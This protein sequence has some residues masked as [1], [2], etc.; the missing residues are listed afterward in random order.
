MTQS[1][2][3]LTLFDMLCFISDKIAINSSD[4]L[5]FNLSMLES[6]SLDI[7]FIFSEILDEFILVV[8]VEFAL[9]FITYTVTVT[10]V[11]KYFSQ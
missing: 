8:L 4:Q 5:S 3:I 11:N 1:L 10:A 2:Y 6:A 7:E 9:E